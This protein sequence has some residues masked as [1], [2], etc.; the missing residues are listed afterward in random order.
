MVGLESTVLDLSGE[1][2]LVLRPGAV[3]LEEIRTFLPGAQRY[4][5]DPQK[6][7]SPGLRHRHYAPDARVTLLRG[8]ERALLSFIASASPTS[9]FL[10]PSDLN[11]DFDHVH[12]IA[13]LP[14]GHPEEAA[15]R[16]YALLRDADR[17]GMEEVYIAEFSSEGIGEALMDRVLRAAQGNILTLEEV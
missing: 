4:L 12:T 11:I 7:P 9:C 16:L 8:S 15:A 5:G 10:L 14:E 3:T 2:P 1:N 13:F 6:A 17:A